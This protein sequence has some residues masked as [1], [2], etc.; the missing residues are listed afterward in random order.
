MVLTVSP[1]LSIYRKY[2]LD[3]WGLNYTSHDFLLAKFVWSLSKDKRL[4]S[5][6]IDAFGLGMMNKTQRT[7][8]KMYEERRRRANYRNKRYIYRLDTPEITTKRKY[9]DERFISVRITRLYF[10]IFEDYQFRKLFRRATKLDGNLESNFC[11]ILECR[12]AS[13]IYRTSMLVN[14]FKIPHFI[15]ENNIYI[16]FRIINKS[17]YLVPIGKFLVYNFKV[18]PKLIYNLCQRL[19]NKVVPFAPPRFM[20]I[21]YELNFFYLLRLPVKRDLIYPIA[22]DIQRLTGYY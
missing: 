1:K 13:I 9:H 11:Y 22:I 16:D 4:R 18:W 10:R 7:F 17:Q 12:L 2:Q 5:N 14:P 21:S 19:R 3:I 8:F 15:A 20:F 6:F